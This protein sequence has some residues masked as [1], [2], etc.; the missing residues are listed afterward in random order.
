MK[1]IIHTLCILTL[2]AAFQGCTVRGGDYPPYGEN[3]TWA[4]CN[5]LWESTYTE[6]D[7]SL[8]NHQIIF[9]TDGRGE[10]SLLYD[11]Y[12]EIWEEHYEFYWQWSNSLQNSLTLSYPGGGILYMDQ[13]YLDYDLFSCLL[14]GIYINFRGQ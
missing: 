6:T 13:V 3:S 8:V 1:K 11:Y 7:G 4:L 2:L 5:H 12:G 9:Y 10:E 14:N